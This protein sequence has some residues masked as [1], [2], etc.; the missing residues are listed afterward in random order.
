MIKRKK[1]KKQEISPERMAILAEQGLKAVKLTAEEKQYL[2]N[3]GLKELYDIYDFA[4]KTIPPLESEAIDEIM[5]KFFGEHSKLWI[6][7]TR[8]IIEMVSLPEGWYMGSPAFAHRGIKAK[9]ISFHKKA[10]NLVVH[11]EIVQSDGR[12]ADIHVRLTDNKSKYVSSIEAELFKGE[13][14]IETVSTLKN[15][16]ITFSSLEMD[17]YILRI[18]DPKDEIT[19][20]A[21]KIEQ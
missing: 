6:R 15:N 8:K 20:I 2:L 21:I 19:S 13:R 16:T 17:D 18:S 11:L 9:N 7:I 1:Y 3:G 5:D 14:C 10:G 12:F 4:E